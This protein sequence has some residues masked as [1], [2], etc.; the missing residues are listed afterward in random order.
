MFTHYKSV[1]RVHRQSLWDLLEKDVLFNIY[2]GLMDTVSYISA[3]FRF[4]IVSKHLCGNRT[5]HV[6]AHLY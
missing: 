5:F 6:F 4:L 2:A 3:L 1:Q